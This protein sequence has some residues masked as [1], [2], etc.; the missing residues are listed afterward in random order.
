M[1]LKIFITYTHYDFFINLHK[2]IKMKF[3]IHFIFT[4]INI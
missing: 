3:L 4:T 1:S 2:K